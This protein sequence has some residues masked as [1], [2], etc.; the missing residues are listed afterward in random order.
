[1]S[2]IIQTIEATPDTLVKVESNNIIDSLLH[3]NKL[4]NKD[5]VIFLINHVTKPTENL[6]EIDSNLM[7]VIIGAFLTLL[8][9]VVWD[10]IKEAIQIKRE[11]NKK[12][13][14]FAALVNPILNYS[15]L[16][17]NNI[18]EFVIELEKDFLE[19]P[20]MKYSPKSDIEK[21]VTKIEEEP[22]FNAFTNHY[23]PYSKSVKEFKAIMS[24]I[25]YQ[26]MQLDQILEILKTSQHYD[27]ERKLKFKGFFEKTTQFA[28]DCIA[29]GKLKQYPEFLSLLDNQLILFVETQK[30]E[31]DLKSAYE[32]FIDPVKNGILVKQFYKIP[33]GLEII[34]NLQNASLI[35]NDIVKHSEVLKDDMKSIAKKYRES[36]TE[37][38][39]ESKKLLKDFFEKEA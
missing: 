5:T 27:Y 35:Y 30:S 17:A 3:T 33:E 31:S 18:E 38:E 13:I 4:P 19:F 32:K 2:L 37:L 29:Q 12:L 24:L 14:Y 11:K 25:G 36:N 10:R 26:N 39:L 16:Q 34:N 23:K 8:F 22:L 9:T 1:M 21:L 28:A 15:N 7:G 6:D 20:M